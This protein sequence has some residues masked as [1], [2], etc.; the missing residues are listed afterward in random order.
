M[1][2]IFFIFLFFSAL[3]NGCHNIATAK[4]NTNIPRYN[5]DFLLNFTAVSDEYKN[6]LSKSNGIGSWN[7]NEFIKMRLLSCDSG[8]LELKETWL[9]LE[10]EIKEGV[11]LK[12][13]VISLNR[14]QNIQ[15]TQTFWPIELP[16]KPSE[17]LIYKGKTLFP[18]LVKL[19][20]ENQILDLKVYLKYILL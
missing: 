18:I 4:E 7:E 6:P 3:F 20:T 13:P 17:G 14:S 15:S 12:N 10:V 1:R 9:G 2:Y 16:L 5:L 8:T 19:S 11:Q